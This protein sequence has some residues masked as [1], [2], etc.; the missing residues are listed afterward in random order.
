MV[1]PASQT[2]ADYA[3]THALVASAIA[4][5]QILSCHD[6]SEGGLAVAAAE[7]SIASGLG[8]IVGADLFMTQAAFAQSPARYL[9]EFKP[10]IW[11]EM[12]SHFS[13]GA[14]LTEVGL[15]QHLRKFTVTTAR[16]RALEISIEELTAAW[17]GTLDW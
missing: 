1:S 11:D 13:R 2:L 4:G 10:A 12:N 5:G 9:I 3:R 17:R 6:I 14:A 8:L 7:M 15:T 16:E